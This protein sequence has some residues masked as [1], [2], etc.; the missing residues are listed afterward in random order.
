MNLRVPFMSLAPGPDAGA[1][2][3][4]I[5]RVIRSGWFILGPEVAAFEEEFARVSGADEAVGVGTGTDAIALSLRALGIGPGDEVI[6]SPLSAAF[7]TLA[8]MMT[9]ATPVFADIDPDRLTIDPSAVEAAITSKTAALLPVH[10]YGQPADMLRLAEIAE[11]HRLAL[12]ED[13]CQA[14]LATAAGR[15]VGIALRQRVQL[16][17][18]K[19]LGA[20]GDGARSLR[21]TR[22]GPHPRL[23]SGQ[24]DR[25]ARWVGVSSRSMG[26]G[27]RVARA[28]AS[29]GEWTKRRQALAAGCRRT[30]Q[31]PTIPPQLDPGHVTASPIRT[32]DRTGLRHT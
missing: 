20:L 31:A 13:A 21:T 15:P 1:V 11:R 10:L 8:I 32:K 3:D 23:R 12:V 7:S 17:P 16:Y 24:K 30:L 28:T 25:A 27:G 14:H 26:A 4:A 19:N 2:R 29:L 9:G 18:T 5:D 22:S 6:T